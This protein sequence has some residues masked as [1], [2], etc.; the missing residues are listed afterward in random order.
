M[1]CF[2][3][4]CP[5]LFQ[6]KCLPTRFDVSRKLHVSCFIFCLHVICSIWCQ[7]V[8]VVFLR[9]ILLFCC[10][11]AVP[12]VFHYFMI[13]C[14]FCRSLIVLPVF[15]HS[16]CVPYFPVPMFMVLYY[17]FL[18]L[19]RSFYK[20]CFKKFGLVGFIQALCLTSIIYDQWSLSKVG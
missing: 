13:I 11:F 3:F 1:F 19:V 15:C 6:G 4:Y 9:V 18:S 8:F 20:T 2:S 12:P 10:C 16:V 14:S 7:F 5:N 17:P